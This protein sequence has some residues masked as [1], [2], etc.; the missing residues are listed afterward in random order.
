MADWV[1]KPPAAPAV[2]PA[3]APA[4]VV[5]PS[6]P[7]GVNEGAGAAEE[8]DVVETP[9]EP[10]AETHAPPAPAAPTPS[11]LEMAQLV[12]R[13][14][15][16]E[17]RASRAEAELQSQR[18]QPTKR[19]EAEILADLA[20]EGHSLETLS[21]AGMRLSPGEIAAA[22]A[23]REAKSLRQELQ[24]VRPRYRCPRAWGKSRV[25]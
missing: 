5:Q 4:P 7:D 13:Q 11:M 9:A 21:K 23:G 24:Q 14:A 22:T 19:T 17:S 12:Q 3:P 2:Q 20:A 18:N 6:K 15:E 8:A 16:A 25:P 1:E 10:V